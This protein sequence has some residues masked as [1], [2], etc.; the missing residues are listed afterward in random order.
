MNL[1][2]LEY[3]Q[4]VA[5]EEHISR[6]AEKLHISQPSLSTTIR[7][8]ENE[9]DTL[10]FDRVRRNIYLNEAG[11]KLLNH[12]NYIFSQ[13]TAL[14]EDLQNKN[15]DMK[16]SLT[17]AINNATFLEDWLTEF[18]ST[19]VN[20]RIKQYTMS[21]DNMLK[22]L[23]DETID[24]AIGNFEN[25][26]HELFSK[27]LTKDEYM[28]AVPS[29]HPLANKKELLFSDIKD[30]PFSSLP[31]SSV[32]CFITAIFDQKNTKPNVIFEGQLSMMCKLLS[33]G[34]ALMFSTR[35]SWKKYVHHAEKQDPQL[36][37]LLLDVHLTPISDLNTYFNL[38][39]CW[40]KDRVLPTMAQ[41]LL[42][43]MLNEF[44]SKTNAPEDSTEGSISK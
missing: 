11:K 19:Q 36:Y 9:L 10:L 40:K 22:A 23:L 25:I 3:F 18:I 13:I 8:L 38:T 30:E 6:A 39:V 28:V 44:T 14:E 35:E 27:I 20:A 12:V 5:K 37:N 7:R 1:S 17:M 34:H 4:I 15:F 33:K 26:P 31:S 43:V 42:S 41:K 32:N 24:L 29:Q 21:E 2:Q 16:H